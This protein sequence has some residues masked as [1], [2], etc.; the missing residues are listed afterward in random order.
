MSI[1]SVDSGAVRAGDLIVYCGRDP[2]SRAIEILADTPSHVAVVR[3]GSHDGSAATITESTIEGGVV[4]ALTGGRNG[5]QTHPLSDYTAD[6]DGWIACLR[7]KDETRARANWFRFYELIGK[8]E[9]TVRYDT[10]GLFEFLLREIP[11]VGVR[12]APEEKQDVMYCCAW[13]CALYSA[14]GIVAGVNWSH[15]RP[16]DLVEMGLWRDWIPIAGHPRLKRFNSL[17]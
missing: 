8:A 7:L 14:L 16:Q 10:A 4:G 5:V 6:Y 3:Q 17:A 9:G 15:T 13:A 1:L 2:L 11:V 12:I